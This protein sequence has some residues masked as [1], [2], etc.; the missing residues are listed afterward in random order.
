LLTKTPYW[1]RIETSTRFNWTEIKRV[2]PRFKLDFD[3]LKAVKDA[4]VSTARRFLSARDVLLLSSG[5]QQNV[6]TPVIFGAAAAVAQLAVC[7][8]HDLLFNS[9]R[10]SNMPFY[11]R[12]YASI[13]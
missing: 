7:V 2:V 11:K 9:F 13:E 1:L 10:S 8:S 5:R 6:T 3:G 12:L 4:R